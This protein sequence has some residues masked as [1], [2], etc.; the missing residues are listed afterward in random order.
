VI[1]IGLVISV[2]ALVRRRGRRSTPTT[3]S[4]TGVIYQRAL[5]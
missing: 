1:L 3:T 2:I 4:H 5:P